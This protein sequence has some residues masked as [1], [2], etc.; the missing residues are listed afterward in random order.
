MQEHLGSQKEDKRTLEDIKDF[1]HLI[2]FVLKSKGRIIKTAYQTF[3]RGYSDYDVM[4]L[5][6]F[7]INKV[8]DP[9]KSYVQFQAEKGLYLPQE[10]QSDPAA[11]LVI[12]RKIELAIDH[13][14][15]K[16]HEE[17]Y[18]PLLGMGV[19]ERIEFCNKVDEGFLLFGKYLRSLYEL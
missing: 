18:N 13:Y 4:N 14:W 15:R 12:L 6:D 10:F 8:R 5:N 16:E 2:M 17:D 3:T 9:L 1:F 11:W 19:I 7:I